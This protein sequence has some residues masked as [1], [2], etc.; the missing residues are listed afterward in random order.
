V[1][2]AAA[3]AP[4]PLA[5]PR[6]AVGALGA[7]AAEATARTRTDRAATCIVGRV[8][9]E[10]WPG[11]SMHGSV[12]RTTLAPSLGSPDNIGPYAPCAVCTKFTARLRRPALPVSPCEAAASRRGFLRM[13]AAE[14][15]RSA[16][17]VVEE[18]IEAT[19]RRP[20]RIATAMRRAG[21]MI[22]GGQRTMFTSAAS[23]SGHS[24]HTS[25]RHHGQGTVFMHASTVW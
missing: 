17:R 8:G 24:V 5:S 23:Q 9:L 19:A 12:P 25:Q 4:A 1:A 21:G 16:I 15:P 3:A 6:S 22:L 11:I 7:G 10:D 18:G 14:A 13:G 2:A 20:W